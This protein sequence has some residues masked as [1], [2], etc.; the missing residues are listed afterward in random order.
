MSLPILLRWPDEL[1]LEK[2]GLIGTDRIAALWRCDQYREAELRL[3][4]RL[5]D[6]KDD[7]FCLVL[8]CLCTSSLNRSAQY[9][10][11]IEY[12]SEKYGAHELTRWLK[13]RH[14]INTLDSESIRLAGD[15]I[16]QGEEDSPFLR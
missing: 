6:D 1:A 3:L 15:D 9:R 12:L 10:Y 8:L 7:F 14:W 2:T 16:W 5:A 11:L 4:A 13:L